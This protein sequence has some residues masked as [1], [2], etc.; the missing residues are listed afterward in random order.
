MKQKER[1]TGSEGKKGRAREV[2]CWPRRKGRLLE[3]EKEKNVKV[4]EETKNEEEEIRTEL[5]ARKKSRPR[6]QSRVP[7]TE[8]AFCASPPRFRSQHGQTLCGTPRRPYGKEEKIKV[9]FYVTLF[10]TPVMSAPLS[11]PCDARRHKELGKKL[12]K[13]KRKGKL[14][15]S[16]QMTLKVSGFWRESH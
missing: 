4:Q 10:G 13:L 3:R 15:Q 5:A 12:L 8:E 9:Y 6:H 14:V 1:R 11:K 2:A 16:T 7:I